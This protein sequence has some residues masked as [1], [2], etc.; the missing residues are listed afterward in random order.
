MSLGERGKSISFLERGWSNP[1]RQ[2]R[3]TTCLGP[4]PH[5]GPVSK[6]TCSRYF[7]NS[8]SH[9]PISKQVLK[10]TPHLSSIRV[11]V[12]STVTV[13]VPG[14]PCEMTKTKSMWALHPWNGST[15]NSPVNGMRSSQQ[16]LANKI[17]FPLLSSQTLSPSIFLNCP[18]ITVPIPQFTLMTDTPKSYTYLSPTVLIPLDRTSRA[19]MPPANIYYIDRSVS[20]TPMCTYWVSGET[21]QRLEFSKI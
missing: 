11:Y 15:I 13:T 8:Y 6:A 21:I 18:Q 12:S 4:I 16:V 17:S 10:A 5:F 19:A 1:R 7:S 20:P 2:C 9:F 14:L 3:D